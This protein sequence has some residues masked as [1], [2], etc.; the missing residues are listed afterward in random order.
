MAELKRSFLKGKM[1]K[2]RDERIIPNG[3]YRDALNIQVSTSE[4]SDVG[5]AQ[6]IRG[7]VLSTESNSNYVFDFPTDYSLYDYTVNGLSSSLLNESLAITIGSKVDNNNSKIYNFVHKASELSEN[8]SYSG[9]LWSGQEVI[10]PRYTGVRSDIIT[11]YSP[12]VDKD[13]EGETVG[14]VT[15]V[16]EVRFAADT[17]MPSTNRIKGLPYISIYDR[18]SATTNNIVPCVRVGMRVQ[19]IRPDGVDLWAGSEVIVTQKFNTQALDDANHATIETTQAPLQI[20]AAY[21]DQGIVYK[22]T[23]ERIL[24]FTQG[25]L[26]TESNSEI[27][28]KPVTPS[29][30]DSYITGINIL[31][32]TLYFTDGRTEPKKINIER[33][34]FGTISA[35]LHSKFYNGYSIASGKEIFDLKKQHICVIKPKPLSPPFVD[36]FST[37]RKPT[38]IEITSE[39]G[40]TFYNDTYYQSISISP[41]QEGTGGVGFP[42]K[43][44]HPDNVSSGDNPQGYRTGETITIAASVHRVHW[45]VGDV[46][47]ITGNTSGHSARLL[48]QSSYSGS[49]DTFG[50]FNTFRALVQDIDTAYDS[51]DGEEIWT[52]QLVENNLIYEDSFI[53]FAYRYKFLDNEYSAI[54]PYSK[55]VFKPGVYRYSAKD[56]F[57]L[58]MENK[59]K[60]LVVRDFV[61]SNVPNDVK[62]VEILLKDNA[63]GNVYSVKTIDRNSSQWSAYSYTDELQAV[64]SNSGQLNL[65]ANKGEMMIDAELYGRTIESGQLERIFDAVPTSAKAQEFSSNRLMYGNYTEN[66]NLIDGSGSLITPIAWNYSRGLST[67]SSTFESTSES[68][69]TVNVTTDPV[70][71]YGAIGAAPPFDIGNYELFYRSNFGGAY[72]GVNYPNNSAFTSEVE[73]VN[74]RYDPTKK[75]YTAPTAGYYKIHAYVKAY[76]NAEGFASNTTYESHAMQL[77]VVKCDANGIV[78]DSAYRSDGPYA[79]SSF[80][81]P[82]VG[83][84][85]TDSS[86]VLLVGDYISPVD[87]T[88]TGAVNGAPSETHRLLVV[89]GEVFLEAGERFCVIIPVHPNFIS[90]SIAN[91]NNLKMHQ[92]DGV[93]KVLAAPSTTNGLA[94]VIG[95]E[96]VKSNRTYEVGVVY[97]DSFGRES[98]VLVDANSQPTISKAKSTFSNKIIS[99]VGH[100]APYWAESYKFYLKENAGEFNNVVLH[101]AY[102]NGDSVHAWLAFSEHEVNKI[103][104]DDYLIGKKKHGANTAITIESNEWR[105]LQKSLTVPEE[106]ENNNAWTATDP[107]DQNGLFFVKIKADANFLFYIGGSSTAST[108]FVNLR[109]ETF[110]LDGAVFETKKKKQNMD[111]GLFYEVSQSY[112]IKLIGNLAE[113]YIRVGSR[114]TIDTEYGDIEDTNGFNSGV[115]PVTVTSVKGSLSS[116]TPVEVKVTTSSQASIG[117]QIGSYIRLKFT[118]EDGSYVTAFLNSSYYSNEKVLRITP[119]THPTSQYPEIK[120]A[121]ALPWYNCFSFSNGVESDRIRE[122]FNADTVYPYTAAGKQA[123]FKASLESRFENG[124]PD[125]KKEF[126]SSDIIFSQIINQDAG[127]NRVSE[128][129]IGDS[130][131]KKLNP[132][133]GSI[134]KLFA[135]NSDL[136]AF[137]ESKVL[138][139]LANK[140]ALFN[141]DGNL[142][143]LQSNN[144][145]GQAIPFSGDYGIAKN[146]ESFASDEYRCYFVD[147]NQG[148]VLRLSMDGITVISN[149]GMVDWFNDHLEFSRSILGSFDD[150]KG[151]YNI[152]VHDVT[153]PYAYKDVYTLSYHERSDG[154]V[155]FKSFTPEAGV[156]L[157]NNYYTFKKSKM[158]AHHSDSYT[159]MLFNNF[160]GQQ[161][162]STITPIINDVS[163]SVKSFTT[164]NYEGTQ[165]KVDKFATETVDGVSYTDGEY[166]NLTEKKGW[167]VESIITDQQDGD[168]LDFKEKEGK[169]FNKI[170]GIETTFTNAA[171]SGTASGNLDFKETSVQGIGSLASI[172]GTGGAFG[173]PVNVVVNDASN[174]EAAFSNINL[175][176]QTSLTGSISA[177]ITPNAGQVISAAD[178][179]TSSSNPLY[180]SI[181]F[182]DTGTPGSPTNT[183][184]VVITVVDQGSLDAEVG[185]EV[186]IEGG[187]EPVSITYEALSVLNNIAGTAGAAVT[188]SSSFAE[189]GFENLTNSAPAQSTLT[190]LP[191]VEDQ[192]LFNYDVQANNSYFFDLSYLQTPI[193]IT[194]NNVD[195]YSVNVQEDASTSVGQNLFTNFLVEVLYNTGST[196]ELLS[197]IENVITLNIDPILDDTQFIQGSQEISGLAQSGSIAYSTNNTLASAVSSES[198]LTIDGFTDTHV[199]FTVTASGSSNRT[200]TITLY[201]AANS[202]LASIGQEQQSITITQTAVET[203]AQPSISISPRYATQTTGSGPGIQDNSTSNILPFS[204]TNLNGDWLQRW[205]TIDLSNINYELIN[206]SHSDLLNNITIS[207]DSSMLTS[208]ALTLHND[209]PNTSIAYYQFKI[210]AQPDGGLARSVNI[211]V[212]HPD[213]ISLVASQ[214]YSQLADYDAAVNTVSITS[215]E[216]YSDYETL[217]STSSNPTSLDLLS[218]TT[219]VKVK[220]LASH[221]NLYISQN[222]GLLSSYYS[223]ESIVAGGIETTVCYTVASA[224]P[225]DDVTIKFA[226][227]YNDAWNTGEYDDEVTVNKYV[228]PTADILGAVGHTVYDNETTRTIVTNT[229]AAPKVGFTYYR[230]N[231]FVLG[232]VA[233]ADSIAVGS[234]DQYPGFVESI[235]LT[236]QQSELEATDAIPYTHWKWNMKI[237]L[238]SNTTASDRG[239]LAAVWNSSKTRWVDEADDTYYLN[240]YANAGV[241]YLNVVSTTPAYNNFP[242]LSDFDYGS[243]DVHGN[244]LFNGDE[245]VLGYRYQAMASAGAKQDFRINVEYNGATPTLSFVNASSFDGTTFYQTNFASSTFSN[246]GTDSDAGGSAWFTTVPTFTPVESTVSGSNGF[247]SFSLSDNSNHGMRTINMKLTHADGTPETMIIFHHVSQQISEL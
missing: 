17:A 173:Y 139:I 93:F 72:S 225:Q 9:T 22:F 55:T 122:D 116:T 224:S 33:L 123:G 66:Y 161:Y 140:D 145:L 14:V 99:Q 45:K 188:L 1:N 59:I 20:T 95:K 84:L 166:Y 44:T 82:S 109:G 124:F 141:A 31:G 236:L 147:K 40:T 11:E 74:N 172:S 186:D 126:K 211:D 162:T 91:E 98:T 30:N 146:P 36:T 217:T 159:P 232:G 235:T 77:A 153:N 192:N 125:Y 214:T 134:Q 215:I 149:V 80:F 24:D 164:I 237:K 107:A 27:N 37:D 227:T 32:D 128:F 144:T 100:N 243:V 73:D 178:F 199:N 35:I 190:L 96:S 184:S 65:N 105:V 245:N 129:L 62:E 88:P 213:D 92:I 130:I 231:G 170:K 138:K 169:W 220:A 108:A 18:A 94:S 239:I 221:G 193:D 23:S 8:G 189:D 118:N 85:D 151:E 26:E 143:V 25:I 163:G 216:Q 83:T 104:E 115:T 203:S 246:L 195:D 110:A 137:C 50:F 47:E 205:I 79:G 67:S 177:T 106:L 183:V 48:L 167:S 53:S 4:D 6:N 222:S 75:M 28:P 16:Y 12:S 200:A 206:T 168:V 119:C 180:S 174:I 208:T 132:E 142:Q 234:E 207:G 242:S 63:Q 171:D 90:N 121:I 247:I 42:F 81:I 13:Y 86:D 204:D 181:I 19:A 202:S 238:S 135:R 240:Q 34:K 219:I 185:F 209:Y 71:T 21:A 210:A 2:D 120:C 51:N 64:I 176:N 101:K 69:D 46:V 7:N 197:D 41:V 156:S 54:S 52:G 103:E 111:L 226:H 218:S 223:S 175:Y 58:G 112:P 133:Y 76:L 3:E 89:N 233:S 191:N 87:G 230:T 68:S 187:T 152:T 5:S 131:V 150:K 70:D 113:Q 244:H 194:A 127:I 148:S 198:F 179:S 158:W 229:S 38:N 241:N 114:V 157:N 160:Y 61:P 165:A 201:S 57:N 56:G 154:W 78:S 97:A 182:T 49:G 102:D 43:L 228:G 155:S 29:V 136:I 39:S 212:A 117:H 60:S 15:D 10:Y 196:D